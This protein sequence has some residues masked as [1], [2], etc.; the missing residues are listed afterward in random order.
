MPDVRE[1]LKRLKREFVKVNL[2]QAGLDALIAFLGINL[3]LFLFDISISPVFSNT[4][5]LAVAAVG[6]F[7]IDLAYR[8]ANYRLEV[9]E[10]RNPKLREILRTARDNPEQDTFVSRAMVEDLLDRLRQVTSD[11][12]IP[13]RSIIQKILVVGGLSFLTLLSGLTS[14]QLQEHGG[15]LLPAPG[16]QGDDDDDLPVLRN[17]SAIYGERSDISASDL[18]LGF[19][20]T[21]EG[22]RERGDTGDTPGRTSDDAAFD[23]AEKQL[24]DDLALAKQYSVAIKSLSEN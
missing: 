11:S 6:V 10:E 4:T 1:V 12:I 16:G 22:E 7:F 15:T 17:T 5:L 21:G 24:S 20:I 2:L 8:T 18:D 3:V 9:Y 23:A 19:N 13:T 14:F